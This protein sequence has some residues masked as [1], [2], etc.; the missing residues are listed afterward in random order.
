MAENRQLTWDGCTNARDL[1]GLKACDGHVTRWGAVVRSDHPARLT[2]EGWSALYAHGVRTIISLGTEGMVE[3]KPD[4]APRPAGITTVSVNVEDVTDLTSEFVQRWASSDLWCTPLYYQD[5][6]TYW[7]ERHAD[8]IKVIAH[9]QPGGVLFHCVR[10]VDRTGIVALLLLALV[11]VEADDIIADY[12]LSIDPEREK[13]L[14]GENTNTRD[15][16]LN[17]LASLDVEAYLREGGLS[18]T[19]LDAIRA[20]FLEPS[21]SEGEV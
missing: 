12:E 8:A 17:T 21:G 1:G 10:G 11:E 13:L 7:P 14:A 2:A 4:I 16:L 19:D 3:D 15:V 6:L 18:Q 5:A 20:R 9:A